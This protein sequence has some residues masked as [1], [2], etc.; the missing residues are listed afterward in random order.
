MAINDSQLRHI[1][2]AEIVIPDGQHADVVLT[3]EQQRASTIIL[4]GAPDDTVNLIFT[5]GIPG[6]FVLINNTTVQIDLGTAGDLNQYNLASFYYKTYAFD[7]SMFLDLVGEPFST[8]ARVA[9]SG[10]YYDLSNKPDLAQVA[11]SGSYTSLVDKPDVSAIAGNQGTLVINV[12]SG[13]ADIT[14]TDDEMNKYDSIVFTGNPDADV[15]V[16]FK[17]TIP[18]IFTSAVNSFTTAHKVNAKSGVVGGAT[19]QLNSSGNN[20]YYVLRIDS[21]GVKN[22]VVAKVATTNLYSDLDGAPELA[23][24]ATSGDYNDL[25]NLPELFSG[26]YADLSD[27]PVLKIATYTVTTAFVADEVITITTG[28]GATAGTTDIMEDSPVDFSFGDATHFANTRELRIRLNGVQQRK[29]VDFVRD[30]ATTGH[31][32][33]PNGLDVGDYF[34]IEQVI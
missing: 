19:V 12:A 17:S 27:V 9:T 26:S 24:V 25:I 23:T 5:I 31:F 20:D 18:K 4:T 13:H 29:G 11:T 8:L 7:G 28:A 10:S 1:F 3:K 32:V 2:T 15:N 33:T 30:S 14:L 16:F 22:D 6:S 21:T 34:E